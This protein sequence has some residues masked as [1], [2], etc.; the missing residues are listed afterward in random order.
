[1]TLDLPTKVQA[2][3]NIPSLS[4]FKVEHCR[5]S[6]VLEYG[7]TDL[8]TYLQQTPWL[9]KSPCKQS[10]YEVCLLWQQMLRAVHCIHSHSIVHKVCVLS[11]GFLCWNH[12][13]FKIVK[14]VLNDELNDTVSDLKHTLK[15]VLLQDL[16]PQNFM[17]VKGKLKLIDFGISQMIHDEV[18]SMIIQ[19]PEGT[20]NYIAP[21]V[22]TFNY[23]ANLNIHRLDHLGLIVACEDFA[24]IISI[25]DSSYTQFI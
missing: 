5:L 4:Q 25:I 6:M 16:K 17:K 13:W 24:I 9:V 15:C 3:N 22:C 14:T 12:T 10:Y 21:E 11:R 23:T 2:N 7:E 20:P 19:Q 18:T 1:M 8:H